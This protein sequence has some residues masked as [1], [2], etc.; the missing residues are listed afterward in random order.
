MELLEGNKDSFKICSSLLV[1]RESV[2]ARVVAVGFEQFY[3]NLSLYKNE[4]LSTHDPCSEQPCRSLFFHNE[5][6]MFFVDLSTSLCFS[7]HAYLIQKHFPL[8]IYI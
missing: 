2:L 3:Q 8:K 4:L 7:Y 1:E 6:K 5:R